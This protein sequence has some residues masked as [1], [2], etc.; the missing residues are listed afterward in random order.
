MLINDH[1]SCMSHDRNARKFEDT[2]LVIKTINLFATNAV[3]RRFE[4]RSDQTKYYRTGICCFPLS[5]QHSGERG[6]S[7]WLGIVN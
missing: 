6:N 4:S 5:M 7:G 2:K 1:Y 3:D